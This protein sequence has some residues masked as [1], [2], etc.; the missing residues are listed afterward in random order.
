MGSGGFVN[1]IW[2]YE[3]TWGEIR[4]SRTHPRGP[5]PSDLLRNANGGFL[6]ET[7][8]KPHALL[9]CSKV[10]RKRGKSVTRD[11]DATFREG[12][13]SVRMCRENFGLV[14]WNT[15]VL[16]C[17]HRV[18][19]AL[20]SGVARARNIARQSLIS[21]LAVIC[22]QMGASVSFFGQLSFC[23]GTLWMDAPSHCVG[24]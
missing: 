12:M 19:Q 5:F 11:S 14:L 2:A 4:G 3:N 23:D 24:V 13:E 22:D 21:G 17:F 9:M 7:S 8:G 6:A 18:G 10:G 1:T 16:S 15:S 20:V